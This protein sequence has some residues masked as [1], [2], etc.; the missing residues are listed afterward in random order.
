MSASIPTISIH[1]KR[2]VS[3]DR[4]QLKYKNV[5]II[6]QKTF[7]I[8]ITSRNHQGSFCR[9]NHPQPLTALNSLLKTSSAFPSIFITKSAYKNKSINST[10]PNSTIQEFCFS[11]TD[12]S[13][14]PN[15]CFKIIIIYLQ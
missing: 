8:Q 5:E 3:R 10:P 15:S 7:I 4:T 12:C 1:Y 13:K 2:N 6:F 9:S 11:F 14:F